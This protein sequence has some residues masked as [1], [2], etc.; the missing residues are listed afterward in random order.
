MPCMCMSS[1]SHTICDGGIAIAGCRG[2]ST[3]MQCSYVRACARRARRRTSTVQS[4]R[5][6]PR[7]LPAD[8]RRL[9]HRSG[10]L[11]LALSVAVCGGLG[12]GLR[13]GLVL[14]LVA[15]GKLFL[16]QAG[17]GGRLV[18]RLARAAWPS[19]VR[20]VRRSR[21]GLDTRARSVVCRRVRRRV[22]DRCHRCD[23]H[24]GGF[25]RALVLFAQLA[26]HLP[27]H[28]RVP[29]VFYRVVGA[30][31]SGWQRLAD[32]RPLRTPLLDH[33]ED[34]AI[35]FSRPRALDHR[36]RQMIEPPLAA[37]L[38]GATGDEVGEV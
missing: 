33:R 8:R 16:D 35:L 19:A 29:A 12:C 15:F 3:A 11:G 28:E 1:P 20:S 9:H 31:R 30:P 36:A 17:Q 26:T 25:R 4:G 7:A 21:S 13:R 10:R 32:P 14:A 18:G 38:C 37:L 27:A 5:P 24:W 6:L 2:M 23:L 22:L 34:Q